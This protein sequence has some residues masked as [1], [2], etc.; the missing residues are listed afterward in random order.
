MVQCLELLIDWRRFVSGWLLMATT[1][2]NWQMTGL[3]C[4]VW[5][6]GTHD[7]CVADLWWPTLVTIDRWRGYGAVFGAGEPTTVVWL[8]CDGQHLS[9][10]TDDRPM[11]QC[12]ELLIDWRCFVINFIRVCTIKTIQVESSCEL[13]PV[14]PGSAGLPP[15]PPALIFGFQRSNIFLL[16]LLAQIQYCDE[17]PWPRGSMFD[18]IPLSRK[19]YVLW[20]PRGS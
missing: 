13:L 11:V 19:D 15:P 4:S 7:C 3:W 6:W 2:H 16:R 1:C 9:L 8:T 17:P 5:S 14:T 12:L 20:E 10:L 18:L